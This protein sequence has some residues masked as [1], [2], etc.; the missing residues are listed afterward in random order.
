MSAVTCRVL[1]LPLVG[2]FDLLFHCLEV[3]FFAQ[4]PSYTRQHLVQLDNLCRCTIDFL[5]VVLLSHRDV[6]EFVH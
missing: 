3:F 5:V 2:V 1:P 6:W 4:K